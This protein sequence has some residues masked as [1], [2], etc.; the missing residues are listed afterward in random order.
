MLGK[1]KGRRTRGR[2][3]MRWLHG[4]INSMDL[5]LSKF[6]EMVIGR[7]AWCVAVR[8]VAKSRTRLSDRTPL[9]PPPPTELSLRGARHPTVTVWFHTALRP[10]LALQSTA[11]LSLNGHHPSRAPRPLLRSALP[12]P[13]THLR[14]PSGFSMMTALVCPRTKPGIQPSAAGHWSVAA[15]NTRNMFC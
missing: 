12:C 1:I 15:R 13:P 6:Q 14:V 5:S 9:S 11:H 2:Q 10:E 7:E 3:R 8:G 4:I